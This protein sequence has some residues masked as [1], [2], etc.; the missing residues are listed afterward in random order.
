M[1]NLLLM[2]GALLIA[3]LLGYVIADLRGRRSRIEQ[4]TAQAKRLKSPTTGARR[5]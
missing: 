4:L 5:G 1:A 3:G 2:L